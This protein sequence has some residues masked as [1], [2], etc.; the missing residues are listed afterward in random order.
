MIKITD[1]QTLISL[2]AGNDIDNFQF[3]D[4]DRITRTQLRKVVRYCR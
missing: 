3:S 4:S 1:I 2:T